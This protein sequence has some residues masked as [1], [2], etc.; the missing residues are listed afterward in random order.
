MAAS[1]AV[2][3]PTPL[4]IAHGLAGAEPAALSKSPVLGILGVIMGAGIVTLTGRMITLG[5][6]I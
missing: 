2:V 1:P 4:Q 3:Q 6:R 5:L